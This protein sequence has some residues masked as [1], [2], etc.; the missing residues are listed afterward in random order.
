MAN[1]HKGNGYTDKA[2]G[3]A[4]A[5]IQKAADRKTNEQLARDR[6][7][8]ERRQAQL[9]RERE[10]R[11]AWIIQVRSAA[12]AYD[13]SSKDYGL[14][15]DGLQD[16]YGLRLNK[17]VQGPDMSLFGEVV[18]EV[19]MTTSGYPAMKVIHSNFSPIQTHSEF[20]LPV[21]C[22]KQEIIK[23][24]GQGEECGSWQA[25]LHA[26]LRANLWDFIFPMM[27]AVH[28]RA[29]PRQLGGNSNRLHGSCYMQGDNLPAVKHVAVQQAPRR[30]DG[31]DISKS[32]PLTRQVLRA[33]LKADGVEGLCHIGE[34]D[35]FHIFF[36]RERIA[37]AQKITLLEGGADDLLFAIS[38]AHPD[39]VSVDVQSVINGPKESAIGIDIKD[40][41]NARLHVIAWTHYYFGLTKQPEVAAKQAAA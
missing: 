40:E 6:I 2:Q 7:K 19:F 38:E 23:D 10:E 32:V 15:C 14:L 24:V 21:F 22:L 36:L 11:Q 35:N 12:E 3:N 8:A 5:G 28:V 34:G 4:K 25:E 41:R 18:L 27:R 31:L 37:G 20:F 30:I 16:R 17:E 39:G 33:N 26:A 29:L 1:K 13:N 9:N